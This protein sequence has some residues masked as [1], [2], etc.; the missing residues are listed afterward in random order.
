MSRDSSLSYRFLEVTLV[1]IAVGLCVLLHRTGAYRLVVLNLFYLPVVLAAFFL[2]R[3]RAGVLSVLSVILAAVVTAL[4]LDTAVAYSSPV[5]IG[6]TLT[7]WGAVLA[8]TA[9]LAGTLS[10]ERS[11]TM[12]E[13]HEAYVGVV[14]VLSRYLHNADQ[15]L[16]ERSA[17]ASKLA[18]Q[19]AT[20]MR[21]PAKQVDDIRVAML[22]HDMESVEVTSRVIRKA[23][24]NV[25]QGGAKQHTFYGSDLAKSLSSVLRGALPLLTVRSTAYTEDQQ[26]GLAEGEPDLPIGS[27]VIHAVRDFVNLVRSQPEAVSPREAIMLLRDDIDED[28]HPAVLHALEQIVLGEDS[29]SATPEHQ[30]AVSV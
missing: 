18:Q 13:L 19:V 8:L 26:D 16:N 24:G 9:M 1:L 23:I 17:M 21:L 2:G 29:G 28:Y 30:A 11:E 14:E 5:A 6:L 27:S 25:A 15:R 3:Y 7:L 12:K 10:D 4:D 22:L 20:R